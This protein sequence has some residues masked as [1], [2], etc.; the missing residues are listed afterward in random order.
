[1]GE[2]FVPNNLNPGWGLKRPNPFQ[3]PGYDHR[4]PPYY[5]LFFPRK[6]CYADRPGGS[7]IISGVN[8]QSSREELTQLSTDVVPTQTQISGFVKNGRVDLNQA[9][10]EVN[11][12]A[13]VIVSE[14]FDCSFE[15]SKELVTECDKIEETGVRAA[16]TV[17]QGKMQE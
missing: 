11:W 5:D 9:F 6:T 15:R 14:T 10:S 4:Y 2:G 8:P 3:P 1:M 17:I 13:S 7:Q 16:I 12:R